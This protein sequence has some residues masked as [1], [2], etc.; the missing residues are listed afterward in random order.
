MQSGNLFPIYF[1]DPPH[2]FD[3]YVTNIPGSGDSPVQV[4][5]NSGLK[6]AYAINY[7]DT[8]GEYIGVYTGAEGSETLRTIIGGG[9]VSS[10]SVVIALN[11]RVS[12][13]SMTASP[14]T[15]GKLTINFMGQ[16][17]TTG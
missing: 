12:L 11:S 17:F 16:G 5:A 8:T 13:R 14:I 9:L 7:I 1:I 3:A 6:A 15:N 2:I 10:T 4:V